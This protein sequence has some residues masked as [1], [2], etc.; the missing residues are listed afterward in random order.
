MT[1]SIRFN[2]CHAIK[3]AIYDDLYLSEDRRCE[4]ENAEMIIDPLACAGD[5]L[6][7]Y[8][9]AVK[10]NDAELLEALKLID[11]RISDLRSA[12]SNFTEVQEVPA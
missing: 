1:C 10:G 9:D 4:I 7:E 12:Y 8:L 5:S 3:S 6:T 11:R 2:I